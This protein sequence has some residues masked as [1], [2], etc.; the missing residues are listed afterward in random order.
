MFENEKKLQDLNKVLP[1]RMIAKMEQDINDNKM[2]L[3]Y[4]ENIKP[5]KIYDIPEDKE[6][7]VAAHKGALYTI[8]DMLTMFR[9]GLHHNDA[10]DGKKQRKP[11]FPNGT[12]LVNINDEREILTIKGYT[13]E[14]YK[15]KIEGE[16]KHQFY[17]FDYIEENFKRL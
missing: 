11:A 4:L 12:S 6:N 15:V 7:G 14:Y 16:K 3:P 13:G 8:G 1:K 2:A 17:T 5:Y 10:P 9:C